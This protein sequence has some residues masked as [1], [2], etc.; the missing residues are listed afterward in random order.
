MQLNTHGLT[1]IGTGTAMPASMKLHGYLFKCLAVRSWQAGHLAQVGTTGIKWN[2]GPT[3]SA[4]QPGGQ[5]S[6]LVLVLE[7]TG[8]GEW[9]LLACTINS[10]GIYIMDR[11]KGSGLLITAH[12]CCTTDVTLYMT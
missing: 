3:S 10:S 8:V 5:P 2:T 12:T 6:P 4:G 1:S 9:V 11:L 7:T